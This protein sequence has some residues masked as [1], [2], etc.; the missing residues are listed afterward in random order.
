MSYIF[1][2]IIFFFC[3]HEACNHGHVKTTSLLLDYG[4]IVNIPGY[5]NDL[6]LHDAVA[7]NH[8]DVVSELLQRGAD[9]NSR[10]ISFILVLF[11]SHFSYYRN[12]QGLTPKDFSRSELMDQL[13]SKDYPICGNILRHSS[14]VRTFDILMTINSFLQDFYKLNFDTLYLSTTYVLIGNLCMLQVIFVS[15]V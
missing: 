1:S 12:R 14:D 7:N 13:L 2:D 5:N 4:A 15:R 11:G 9:I 10:Y 8:F 6:P 3:Q